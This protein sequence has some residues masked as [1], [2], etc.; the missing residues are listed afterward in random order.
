M[1]GFDRQRLRPVQMVSR[2][3][4]VVLVTVIIVF[5]LAQL[6]SG[7]WLVARTSTPESPRHADGLGNTAHKSFR[8]SRAGYTKK[9][10]PPSIK[11]IP[12]EHSGF[13]QIAR[14]EPKL[15]LPVA[16]LP[17]LPLKDSK[18]KIIAAP[19]TVDLSA[20]FKNH[21]NSLHDGKS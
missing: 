7:G 18:P 15:H 14:L 1:T 10:M 13:E 5:A 2:L 11:N 8:V 3:R 17:D 16:A 9:R 6:F 21:A 4:Q 19:D 12:G 20:A